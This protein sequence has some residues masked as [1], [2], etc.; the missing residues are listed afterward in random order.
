MKLFMVFILNIFAYAMIRLRPRIYGTKLFKPMIWNFKLSVLP[1]FVLIG[2][3]LSFVIVQYI[4][5]YTGIKSI[6]YLAKVFGF[7]GIIIWILL[8]PNSSY[9]ITELNLTHRE[10][11]KIE[12]ALWY[13]IVAVTAFALSG[14][15]NTIV[16][17]NILQYIYLIVV[18]PDIVSIIDGYFFYSSAVV[19]NILMSVGIYL[20]RYI[21]FNSWDIL[22]PKKFLKSFVDYFRIKGNIKDFL[23]FV[24]FHSS[25]FIIIYFLF[26]TDNIFFKALQK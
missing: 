20:G 24:F 14:I 16:N 22:K 15:L 17:I 6:S 5:V 25:F 19:I 21:R 23:L 26:N 12:V 8:L 11:D 13:D 7:L 18:D 4:G 10:E 9:L 2:T 1:F 3:G